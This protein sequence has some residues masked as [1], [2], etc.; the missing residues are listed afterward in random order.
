MA[1]E[2]PPRG[3]LLLQVAFVRSAK[4][5]GVKRD[6]IYGVEQLLAHKLASPLISYQVKLQVSAVSRAVRSAGA[7]IITTRSAVPS[8]KLLAQALCCG[9]QLTTTDIHFQI[10]AAVSPGNIVSGQCT[11]NC[12]CAALVPN[13][14]MMCTPPT[15]FK[16]G[17]SRRPTAS[18][19]C[20]RLI[21]V[22]RHPAFH[23][24]LSH[25][26][27]LLHRPKCSVRPSSL[28]SH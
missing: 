25:A 9:I 7:P 20:C 12:S 23:S 4:H 18:C 5:S 6:Q 11:V 3:T 21:H 17:T 1:G 15:R 28:F 14:A 19:P 24:T 8:L 26:G 10:D 13:E 27:R 16:F 22:P 2:A